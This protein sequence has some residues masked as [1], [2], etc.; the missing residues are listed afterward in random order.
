MGKWDAGLEE[1]IMTE[2]QQKHVRLTESGANVL[3]K[4]E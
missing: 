1:F 3:A 4:Y 2:L